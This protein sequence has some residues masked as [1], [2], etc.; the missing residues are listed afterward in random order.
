[1]PLVSKASLPAAA[2][3]LSGS[4]EAAT[5][6]VE[7]LG[8]RVEVRGTPGLAGCVFGAPTDTFLLTTPASLMIYVATQPVDFRKGAD[9]LALLAKETLGHDSIK[10]VAVTV[11]SARID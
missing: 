5:V 8:A 7:F 1:M 10:G 6:T 9:G 4:P 11:Q 2:E 3:F